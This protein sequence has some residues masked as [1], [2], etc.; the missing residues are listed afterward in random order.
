[1]GLVCVALGKSW[2]LLHVAQ[3]GEDKPE[4]RETINPDSK[5]RGRSKREDFYIADI[6]FSVDLTQ[7]VLQ[8]GSRG[9]E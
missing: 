5:P 9:F 2:H 8:L 1:M 4:G 3:R 6:I 7:I